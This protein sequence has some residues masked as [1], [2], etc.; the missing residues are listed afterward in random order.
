MFPGMEP[1]KQYTALEQAYARNFYNGG[2]LGS[3]KQFDE[4][5]YFL[6]TAAH[7]TNHW[8]GNRR[9]FAETFTG[10]M[11]E[12][13]AAEGRHSFLAP[14]GA[15]PDWS[16]WDERYDPFKAS[17]DEALEDG[18]FVLDIHGVSAK[19][20]ADLFIGYGPDPS[21]EA[22]EFAELIIEAFDGYTVVAGG[23]FNATAPNTVRSYVQST[24]G[25][26]LQLDL[27]PTM[28][29]P[30]EH[31]ETTLDFIARFGTVLG[32]HSAGRLLREPVAA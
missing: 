15:V 29:N 30:H 17:L 31:P 4:P 24:G 27:A 13:L 6:L 5:S 2:D 1:L 20:G 8:T 10:A 26:G 14:D 16:Y 12:T 19:Y 32:A 25:D 7:A 22:L 23:R 21:E 28:R 18:K 9:R 3:I 11:A